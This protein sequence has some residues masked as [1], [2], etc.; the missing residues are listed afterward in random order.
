MT[1]DDNATV[2]F[3]Y[4]EVSEVTAPTTTVTEAELRAGN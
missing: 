2:R 1:L 4:S 3:F